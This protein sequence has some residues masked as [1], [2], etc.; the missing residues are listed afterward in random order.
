LSMDITQRVLDDILPK[1]A[2][3][4]R[5]TGHEWNSVVKDW[6]Q[7]EV[8]VALAYPDVYEV[9]MSNLGL[10]ILYD[11]LNG[12]EGILAERVYAPWIDMEEAMRRAGIPLYS[13]ESRRPLAEFDIIGF[14]L[15]YELN[16]TNVLNMLHLAGLSPL[17]AERGDADPLIIGGGSCTYN[18]EPLADFFDLFVIGEGEEVLLELVNAYRRSRITNHESRRPISCGRR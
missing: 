8:K 15:Q 18:A 11:L 12:E 14:S 5:Y 9:G 1:V 7:V 4:A 3:P 16:Y 2:K 17:A 6:D 10:M 13:L